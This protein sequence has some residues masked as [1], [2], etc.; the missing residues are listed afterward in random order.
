MVFL[1]VSLLLTALVSAGGDEDVVA[2]KISNNA[3][4]KMTAT[5]WSGVD[6]LYDCAYKV[7]GESGWLE[8]GVLFGYGDSGSIKGKCAYYKGNK[9]CPQGADRS[10]YALYRTGTTKPLEWIGNNPSE[11]LTCQGD[12]DADSD[13]PGS[14]ICTKRPF[15]EVSGCSEGDSKQQP[16]DDY[17]THPEFSAKAPSVNT[18]YSTLKKGAECRSRDFHVGKFA[19]VQECADAIAEVGEKHFIYGTGSKQG[20]CYAELTN[21]WQ[22]PEGFENDQ[23]DFYRTGPD[24]SN[25]Y[26]EI[27]DTKECAGRETTCKN[28]WQKRLANDL[29]CVADCQR[30]CDKMGDKCLAYQAIGQYRDRCKTC[31]S[32]QVTGG[33]EIV[34]YVKDPDAR[35]G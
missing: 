14:S 15:N 7:W 4:C 29:D 16:T 9:K 17:C 20:H 12:C 27:E 25:K 34:T 2:Q 13:C 11:L 30:K 5:V 26:R 10:D 19:T 22:C 24:T 35:Y 28:N 1:L 33:G 32:D 23:Y 21:R 3:A 31:S 18:V 6:S 8:T